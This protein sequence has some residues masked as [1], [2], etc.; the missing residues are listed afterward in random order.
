MAESKNDVKGTI[1]LSKGV[2][3]YISIDKLKHHPENPRKDLGDL[4]EL[5]DSIKKNGILQNLTVVPW[6]SVLTGQ[7]VPDSKA[8]EEMGYYVVI[9][10][11]RLEAAKMAGIKE[12]PCVISDMSHQEQVSTMLVENMQRNDLTVYEQA[13]GFQLMLDLGD[14]VE[15]ITDKTGFSQSTVRRRIKLL[16]LD[17]KGFKESVERGAT[18]FDYS[19]LDK[20]KST[21]TKNE[22]LKYLGTD[23]FK[24]KLRQA[25]DDEKRLEKK[26]AIIAVLETFATEIS[27]WSHSEYVVVQYCYTSDG[28]EG[29][30]VPKDSDETEYFY[31]VP[32]YG[33][34]ALLK[35][36]EK[37][38]NETTKKA[39]ELEHKRKER[40]EALKDATACAY[41][42]R[43]EFV[44]NVSSATVKKHFVEIIAIWI[45]TQ[46]E[47]TTCIDEDDILALFPETAKVADEDDFVTL[48]YSDVLE[49]VS[50]SP[51]KMLWNMIYLFFADKE[52][53]GYYNSWNCT[54]EE[55]QDLD[56][57]Y[58]LLL[59]LGYQM[60]DDEKMLSDGTHQ[61]FKHIE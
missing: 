37:I 39:D 4:T 24:F 9:G 16:E 19:E 29:V 17:E 44:N 3:V 42:L 32:Q 40:Q 23:S 18:L 34:I 2:L 47:L 31:D 38:A 52:Y 49:L 45:K 36:R 33:T 41:S 53:N 61:L 35:K 28:A 30:K 50:K 12:L 26:K 15:T 51:E 5:S 22:L 27:E 60:S 56:N 11:R 21:E 20:V 7:G 13:Q 57:I 58:S 43:H 6:F 25:I 59:K 46:A 54:Y 48:N 1:E 14:T 8:Q 55:N 10:N